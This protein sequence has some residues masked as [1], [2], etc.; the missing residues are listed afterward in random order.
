VKCG[1]SNPESEV[2]GLGTAP[3][4]AASWTAATIPSV[5]LGPESAGKDRSHAAE[6]LLP[7]CHTP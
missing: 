1:Q 6:N 7:L 5:W 2:D 3:T 4:F